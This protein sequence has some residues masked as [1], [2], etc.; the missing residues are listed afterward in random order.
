MRA[1]ADPCL[2]TADHCYL[3][4]AV[5]VAVTVAIFALAIAIVAVL[6]GAVMNVST[7]GSLLPP[8]HLDV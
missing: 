2:R 8:L 3:A 4:A 7:M 6:H 1:M 5:V